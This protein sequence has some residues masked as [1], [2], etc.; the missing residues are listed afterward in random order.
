MSSTVYQN[1]TDNQTWLKN[2][3]R[4]R[5][6][7]K[8]RTIKG[9]QRLT[10]KQ[11]TLSMRDSA[12][13]LCIKN[14]W[15]FQYVSISFT[16]TLPSTFTKNTY[17]LQPPKKGI[18]LGTS[19]LRLEVSTKNWYRYCAVETISW[20]MTE[21]RAALARS[22]SRKMSFRSCLLILIFFEKNDS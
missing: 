14:R 13:C 22:F 19:P 15:T 12:A 17:W 18:E 20:L 10:V 5:K 6:G 16:V 7:E 3:C 21:W 11:T 8:I 9:H 1:S 4:N 2:V